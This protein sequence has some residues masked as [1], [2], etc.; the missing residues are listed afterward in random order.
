M[1]RTRAF[2]RH[3]YE[4]RKERVRHRYYSGW[5]G[6]ERPT[7]FWLGFHAGTPHPCSRYCCGNPRKWFGE[8][9]QQERRS[10]L[11]LHD[12]GGV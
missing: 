5:F 2:R 4:V 7:P 1:S 6:N 12:W 8:V 3:Q 10:E 11:D 9:T